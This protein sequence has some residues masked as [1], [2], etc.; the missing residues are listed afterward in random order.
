[1]STYG[2]LTLSDTTYAGDVA[3]NFIRAAIVGAE[4]IQNGHVYVKDGIKKKFTIPR[5]SIADMIQDYAAKPITSGTTT[6][7]AVTLEP[8]MYQL[9]CEFDPHDFEDHWYAPEMQ[10]MLVDRNL[11]QTFEAS[12]VA[13]V[14][15]YHAN[16][17]DY[18][19]WN[20][21]LT[22]AT[23]YNKFD[24]FIQKG[25]ANSTVLDVTTTVTALTASNIATEL[26]KAFVLIPS[27]L[28]FDKNFK[29]F[30]SYATAELYSNYQIAQTNKGVDVS[31]R[32]AMTYKGVQI[33]PLANFPD[34]KILGA[35]ATAGMDS[36][37]WVGINSVDDNQIT[38]GK[39]QANSEV[40]FIKVLFKAD[41]QFG[42]GKEVVLYQTV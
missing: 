35:K 28:K 38:M 8:N 7:D 1:M 42:F 5:L 22:G 36:N 27:A 13:A 23:P 16:Y 18:A 41:T 40:R 11:P 6:I 17:F 12:M 21:D 33:V 34:G 26:E 29:F 24:G 10:A 14:L 15:E 19:I 3:S 39:L 2:G 32:G 31:Q 9:Y 37:L 4:T 20:G 30:V 25:K